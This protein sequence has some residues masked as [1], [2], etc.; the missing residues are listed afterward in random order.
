MSNNYIFISRFLP[1]CSIVCFV[2]HFDY[3]RLKNHAW[4]YMKRQLLTLLQRVIYL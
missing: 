3:F 4:A 2:V 1:P